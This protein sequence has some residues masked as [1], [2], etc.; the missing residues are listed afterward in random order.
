MKDIKV[1]SYCLGGWFIFGTLILYA[2]I[3]FF[4]FLIG[5]EGRVMQ[6]QGF[7]FMYRMMNEM[8]KYCL[9]LIFFGIGYIAMGY[10]YEKIRKNALMIH[11]ALSAGLFIWGL[12]A[13]IKIYPA[14]SGLADMIPDHN[15][16][17]METYNKTVISGSAIMGVVQFVFPQFYL[18]YL[19]NKNNKEAADEEPT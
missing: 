12:I 8:F 5:M 6:E 11:I 15:D 9:P 10:Y 7:S 3:S 19:I 4:D 14:I 16:D 17:F 18:G 1:F 2:L 13:A